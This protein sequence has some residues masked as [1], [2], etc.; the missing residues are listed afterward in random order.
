MPRKKKVSAGQ[1]QEKPAPKKKDYMIAVTEDEYD[2]Q[3][4][5]QVSEILGYSGQCEIECTQTEDSKDIGGEHDEWV[6]THGED[7]R[8]RVYSKCYVGGLNNQ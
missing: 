2:A 5:L 3:P 1:E 7:G 8:D 6:A 4:V